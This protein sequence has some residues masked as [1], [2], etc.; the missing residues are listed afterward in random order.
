MIAVFAQEMLDM[1]YV[2]EVMSGSHAATQSA[3]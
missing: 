2:C 3:W 1:Q